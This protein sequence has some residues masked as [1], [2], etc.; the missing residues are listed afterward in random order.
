MPGNQ[1]DVQIDTL[2]VILNLNLR[3]CCLDY[4]FHCV[5]SHLCTFT[6]RQDVDCRIAELLSTAMGKL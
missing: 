6:W 2:S 4:K 5:G 3:V 1:A